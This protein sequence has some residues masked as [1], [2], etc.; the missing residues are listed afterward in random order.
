MTQHLIAEAAV[1]KSAWAPGL[2]RV[3]YW[4]FQDEAIYRAEQEKIFRGPH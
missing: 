2:T 1:A 4:V 3:P